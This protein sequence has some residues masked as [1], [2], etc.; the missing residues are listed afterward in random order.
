MRRSDRTVTSIELIVGVVKSEA[1]LFNVVP[2]EMARRFRQML[3]HIDPGWRASPSRMA[4]QIPQAHPWCNQSIP[5]WRHHAEL[6]HSSHNGEPWFKSQ[7]YSP[8]RPPWVRSSKIPGNRHHRFYRVPLWATGKSDRQV[9]LSVNAV[10]DKPPVRWLMV[11]ATL[12]SFGEDDS[13]VAEEGV[14]VYRSGAPVLR[15]RVD[16]IG[17]KPMVPDAAPEPWGNGEP[18]PGTRG[19]SRISTRKNLNL[20]P[21]LLVLLSYHGGSFIRLTEHSLQAGNP[22]VDLCWVHVWADCTVMEVV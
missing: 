6:T 9:P 2:P 14:T 8:W 21:Y 17:E 16:V 19:R 4:A 11:Y 20:S 7:W 12:I 15:L 3:V 1:T 18:W 5:A 10:P 22:V 13:T